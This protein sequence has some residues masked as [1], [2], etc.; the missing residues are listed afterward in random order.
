MVA[1]GLYRPVRLE[2]PTISFPGLQ[3]GNNWGGGAFDPES[4]LLYLNTSDL[5]QVTELV[6][7]AG[8]LAYERGPTS[9]RFMQPATR[10]PCQ[11][12]PW[13]QLHA[14]DT[15]TG[16]IKLK[17]EFPNTDGTLFAN[18]FVNVRMPVETKPNATLAP[19][20]AIQRGVAGTFVY[21][22][23]DD[24]TVTVTPVQIGSTQGEITQIESG[25]APGAMVVV[26]GA[27][28]L[29]EGAKVEVVTRDA[30]VPA[31]PDAARRGPRGKDGGERPG[32]RAARAKEG[33]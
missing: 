12:P 24:K 33:A 9:G 4:G 31:S 32:G 5:G 21:V 15:A 19:S 13:G 20:A 16:T 14:I 1:G 23:K 3:G 29:R 10:L 7:S 8:P 26:D 28:R 6:K 2:Q 30:P 22:V 18:Q 17:A 25:V 11:A 27:D